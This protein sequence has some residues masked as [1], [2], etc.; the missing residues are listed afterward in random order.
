VALTCK[1]HIS[2][3]N[4]AKCHEVLPIFLLFKLWTTL[5]S[6]V[7]VI[8]NRTNSSFGLLYW[9][10]ML[11]KTMIELFF[12]YQNWAVVGNGRIGLIRSHYFATR[13]Q[14]WTIPLLLCMQ[15]PIWK[16]SLFKWQCFINSPDTCFTWFLFS[17][18]NSLILLAEGSWRKLLHVSLQSWTIS[19]PGVLC[20]SSP[21]FSHST[22]LSKMP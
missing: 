15:D 21:R 7:S 10:G 20:S 5:V 2:L 11:A 4:K 6:S 16:M 1:A 13:W 14:W 19:I 18:N 9:D 3:I 17:P 8:S 12:D 22:D